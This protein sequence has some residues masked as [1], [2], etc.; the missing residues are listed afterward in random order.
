MIIYAYT[1]GPVWDYSMTALVAIEAPTVQGL[2]LG[3]TFRVQ[4]L[5]DT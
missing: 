4:S 3:A 1:I 2:K 5:P